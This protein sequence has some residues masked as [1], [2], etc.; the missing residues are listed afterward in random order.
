[1]KI[2]RSPVKAGGKVGGGSI[3]GACVKPEKSEQV[4][5]EEREGSE[6]VDMAHSGNSCLDYCGKEI[7][8]RKNTDQWRD[9]ES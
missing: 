1:M 6:E 4:W 2:S 3:Q 7:E 9:L 8:W 5:V